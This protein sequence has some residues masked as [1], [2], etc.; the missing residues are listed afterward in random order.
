MLL[1]VS[2]NLFV[3]ALLALDLGVFHRRPHEIKLKESLVWSGIWI[4][5]ALVFNAG[6]YCVQGSQKA[7][8]FLTGYIIEKSLS[9][10]N[11]FVFLVI[12]SYFQV[13]LR[14][15][16]GVLFWG[17]LGAL[18]L[19]AVFIV[20]GVTLIERFHWMIYLFGGF[21][22]YTGVKMVAD[23]D[24]HMDIEKNPVMKWVRHFLR[25]TPEYE[26]GKFFVKKDGVWFATPLLVVLVAV[27]IADVIFAV[28]SIPA[29][30]AVTR[31]T[32]I[33]YSS[34]VFAILGLRA[35]YFALAGIIRLFTYLHAGLAAI[36][37]FVGVKMVLAD[38]CRIPTG[39]SLGVIVG[40]L[41]VSAV[42]SG[43]TKKR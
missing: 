19:R 11:I 43:M 18:V 22:I 33:V 40:I 29:I 6:V 28:D 10:D 3:L 34:N 41:L 27:D 35:L 1:W 32:F 16:H 21:L 9:L 4:A 26:G 42:A 20:G 39:F 23:K 15:Q 38:F 24:R 2:F 17:I 31:D 12:L 37:I 8:E 25:V 14:Y 13:P 36:L 7:L 5:L 30:L